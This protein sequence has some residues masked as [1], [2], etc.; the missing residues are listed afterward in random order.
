MLETLKKKSKK[1][2]LI[3]IVISLLVMAGCLVYSGKGLIQFFQGPVSI[4][5][6][7]DLSK[8]EGKYINYDVEILLDTYV[9][10][11]RTNSKTHVTKT[12]A[13]GYVVYDLNLEQSFGY[14][15]KTSDSNLYSDFIEKSIAALYGEDSKP[16]SFQIT[17]TL[18]RLSGE[19]LRY[20]NSSVE[21]IF[22]DNVDQ[23]ATPFCV[24]NGTVAGKDITTVFTVGI[25][26][27]L[28]LLYL[29]YNIMKLRT[30]GCLKLFNQYLAENPNITIA[31][32][33]SDFNCAEKAANNWAGKKWMIFLKGS[34]VR[35]LDMNKLVW[36]YY[37][38]RTGR[39]P[40]SKIITY[41]INKKCV[42][43]NISSSDADIILNNWTMNQPHMIIGYDSNLEHT[44]RKD[45]DG[46]LNQ[47][48]TPAQSQRFE[49][50]YTAEDYNF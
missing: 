22:G 9:E 15:Q 6:A 26:A 32:I 4:K 46:F 3:R 42:E 43:I 17:G 21:E 39:R 29:I 18:T 49:S 24:E 31:S 27:L 40:E 11:T 1:A 38:R 30:N 28:A 8:F 20:Y 48:Y 34:S 33:E 35:I 19:E 50:A 41:D 47:K 44:F 45:F 23:Y 14:I 16:E 5:N 37:Y 12:T 25:A 10:H 7:D 13:L 2:I 36:A